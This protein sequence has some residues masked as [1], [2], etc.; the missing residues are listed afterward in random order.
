MFNS[1]F[2]INV[3]LN[4]RHYF[5]TSFRSIQTKEELRI[6]YADFERK[7]LEKDGYSLSV[8]FIPAVH[9]Y[10][11]IDTKTGNINNSFYNTQY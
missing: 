8:C 3:S 5:A 2:E 10:V 9:Y 11:N 1:H 7:F 4:G 6:V